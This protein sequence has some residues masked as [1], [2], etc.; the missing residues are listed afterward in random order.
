M[1][2]KL[3]SLQDLEKLTR[4]LEDTVPSIKGSFPDFKQLSEE[5]LQY[6]KRC[7]FYMFGTIKSGKSTLANALTGGELLP[8]GSGVKTFSR[9]RVVHHS[10][11]YGRIAFHSADQLAR[12]FEHDFRMLGY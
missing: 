2:T 1:T 10:A 11:R 3:S 6:T 9:A 5:W 12:N 8:R 4:E 7:S